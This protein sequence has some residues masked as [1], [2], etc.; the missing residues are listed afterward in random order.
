MRATGGLAP[1]GRCAC[2][3][4]HAECCPD[5]L[6]GVLD[7]GASRLGLQASGAP[8]GHAWRGLIDHT[9]LKPDATQAEIETLCREAREYSFAT[10]CLNPTWVPLAARL[11]RGSP[12]GVCTVVG[13]PAGGDDARRQAVRDAARDLRW[14]D[15]GGHGDQHRRAQVGRRAHG[16]G[17][18]RG[19]G[20]RL[21]RRGRRQQGDHRDGPAHRR[22]E[23][24]RVHAGQ[25]RGRDVRQDLDRIRAQRRDTGRRGAD[26][27]RGG[28]RDGREG[29]GRR[30]RPERRAGDGQGRRHAHRR[31][32]R[33]QDRAGIEGRRP[34]PP[35]RRAATDRR[36]SAGVRPS[37]Q[38][39]DLATAENCTPV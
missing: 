27:A 30:A 18:H 4:V 37:I 28:R 17:R 8:V 38:L 14:R 16:A 33:R 39:A 11:L 25:G 21:P 2:H 13:L 23:G 19:R 6:Q 7:A 36:W 35:A 20:R 10:V 26:A 15:R 31:Q 12:V 24:H 9:L 29:R 5:R 1:A 22:G 32:R 34:S 3:S